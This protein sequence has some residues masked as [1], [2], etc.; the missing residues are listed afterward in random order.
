MD[1]L[2]LPAYGGGMEQ[3]HDS[4]HVDPK[5]LI[6]DAEEVLEAIGK[7]TF[8]TVA[9]TSPE[10]WPHAAGVLY[11]MA[12]DALYVSTM[13]ASRKARNILENPKV[14]VSVP[15]RRAPVG[16]PSNISFQTT[17]QVLELDDPELRTAAVSGDLKAITG[18]GELDLPGGCFLRIAL[19]RKAVTYGMGMSLL[20]LV[21]DPMNASGVAH[22]V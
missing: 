8:A 5:P 12:G 11:A 18:H 7:R 13:R 2:T 9:T 17:A 20:S 16:P 22:L 4:P 3:T 10:G 21:R 1:T 6:L 15:V 19:P 14:A